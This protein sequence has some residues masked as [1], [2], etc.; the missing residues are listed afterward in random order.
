VK[1]QQSKGTEI[2]NE[3]PNAELG[4]SEVTYKEELEEEANIRTRLWSS[5]SVR[6][7][8][9]EDEFAIIVNAA[10]TFFSTA[11]FHRRNRIVGTA[12]T[13]KRSSGYSRHHPSPAKTPEYATSDDDEPSAWGLDTTQTA[14]GFQS[15]LHL[16]PD[17]SGAL[18][19]STSLGNLA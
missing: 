3:E 14:A 11:V 2:E 12:G 6:R 13:W 4:A 17:E 18:P 16:Y 15:Y 1:S 7:G 8:E 5:S 10:T 9:L 19:S